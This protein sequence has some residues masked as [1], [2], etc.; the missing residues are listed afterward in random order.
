MTAGRLLLV[1]EERTLLVLVL[2]E[3]TLRTGSVGAG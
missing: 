1:L 3:R 2:E